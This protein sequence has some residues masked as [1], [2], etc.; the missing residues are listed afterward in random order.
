MLSTRAL[1]TS[2]T[3]ACTFLEPQDTKTI[4]FT[5][6][7]CRCVLCDLMVPFAD[8]VPSVEV[9]DATAVDFLTNDGFIK[10]PNPNIPAANIIGYPGLFVSVRVSGLWFPA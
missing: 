1:L 8:G 9:C 7:L 3:L 2:A 4:S 6:T 10:Q 5:K